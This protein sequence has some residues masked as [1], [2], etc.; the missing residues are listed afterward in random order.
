MQRPRLMLAHAI[1][2]VKCEHG[3]LVLWRILTDLQSFHR[4]RLTRTSWNALLRHRHL[5]RNKS[6]SRAAADYCGNDHTTSFPEFSR[7]TKPA[8]TDSRRATAL[9]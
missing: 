9:F 5:N 3:W 2:K 8:G 4:F 6:S 7:T 1:G